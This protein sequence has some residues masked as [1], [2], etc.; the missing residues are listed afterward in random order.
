MIVKSR[1]EVAGT[2]GDMHGDKWHSLRLL[3]K[4]D[5]MGVTLTDTI[6]DP[7]F[8]MVL[9]QKNHLEACYCLEGEGTIEELDSGKVHA[10]R[11]GTLYAMDDHDRHRLRAGTRMRIV[12][13]FFPALTGDEVHDADG[14]L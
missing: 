9:W 14:S 5:G 11:P 6:L 4:D 3:H 7:G 12:C 8:D 2:K 10:I 13:T 1:G